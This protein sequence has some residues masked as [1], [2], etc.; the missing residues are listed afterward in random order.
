MTTDTYDRIY[1]SHERVFGNGKPDRIIKEVAQ[2]VGRG[3]ALDLGS[4]EGRNAI[5]LATRGFAVT[6]LDA[7]PVGI[8]R[9]RRSACAL[10]VS[11]NARVEDI[12]HF[13]L[14]QTYDVF[15]AVLV[16]HHLKR[17]EA[18]HLL[19]RL[20]NAS[21]IGSYHAIVVFTDDGDFF[22]RDPAT[23]HFFPSSGEVRRLYQGWAV[24]DYSLDTGPAFATKPDGAPMTNTVAR[25]LAKRIT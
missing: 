22:R 8:A 11:I 5:Y 14:N 9:M 18:L 20:R 10:G 3:Q 19:R 17:D 15:V 7:S 4:G 21:A 12:R 24:L 23:D 13:V 6:A 1:S 25:L 2:Q 16:L